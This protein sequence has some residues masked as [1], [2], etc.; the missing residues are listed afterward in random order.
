MQLGDY[1][2][3]ISLLPDVTLTSERNSELKRA[4]KLRGLPIGDHRV[5][6]TASI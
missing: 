3:I 2:K 6:R 1:R 5:Q 4:S